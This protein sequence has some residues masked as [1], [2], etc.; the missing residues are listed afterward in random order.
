MLD[1]KAPSHEIEDMPKRI[2]HSAPGLVITQDLGLSMM[3]WMTQFFLEE[4]GAHLQRKR[5]LTVL[6]HRCEAG[7]FCREPDFLD[8]K[9]AFI[10]Y[11]VSIGLGA[12][13]ARSTRASNTGVFTQPRA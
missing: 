2:D 6:D 4:D 1:E 5:C 11:G 7:Y 12:V 13:S 8:P 10:N 3:L 9:F